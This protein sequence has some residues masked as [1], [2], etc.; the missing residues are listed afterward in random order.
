MSMGIMA[1]QYIYVGRNVE[2]DEHAGKP[3]WYIFNRKSQQAIGRILWYPRWRQWVATFAEESV[4]SSGC[5]KD[6]KDAME[7][8]RLNDLA[9][10]SRR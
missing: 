3:I 6:V 10:A 2:K 1:Y 7:H 5:L 9:A 8:I 4:W